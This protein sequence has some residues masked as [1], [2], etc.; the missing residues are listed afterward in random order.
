MV[1]GTMQV[2]DEIVLLSA[3]PR[4]DREARRWYSEGGETCI[5]LSKSGKLSAAATRPSCYAVI[6]T[7]VHRHKATQ[8]ALRHGHYH[9]RRRQLNVG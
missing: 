7:Q 1:R 2:L 5:A 4:Q 9:A 8:Y 6:A 3:P